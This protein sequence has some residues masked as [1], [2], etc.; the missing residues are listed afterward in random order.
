MSAD[1]ARGIDRDPARRPGVPAERPPQSQPHTQAAASMRQDGRPS[2][3]MES[4]TPVFGTAQPP[5]GLSGWLRR[6]AYGIP[7][8]VAR[9]WML[10]ILA[11]R[12]DVLEHRVRRRPGMALALG[13]GAVLGTMAATRALGRR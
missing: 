5:R 1:P 3:V 4:R 8:H 2:G 13:A 6:A 10:L 7:D 11:D 12:V 9:H